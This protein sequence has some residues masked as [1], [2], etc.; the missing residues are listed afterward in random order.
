MT[1]VSII[2]PSWNRAEIILRAVDSALA[3]TLADVEVIVVDNGSTDDTLD[4]LKRCDDPRLSVVVHETNLGASGGR[5]AGLLAAT[6]EFVG[7]LDS[8]DELAPTW[9][10]YL[11]AAAGT[12]TWVATC[13]FA[14]VGPDGA[15]RY[16]HPAKSLGPAFSGLVGPF[17]AGT[18]IVNRHVLT[19]LGGYAEGLAYSENTELALRLGVHCSV[20]HNHSVSVD[21]PLLRWHHDESHAYATPNRRAG[22]AYLLQHHEALLARDPEMLK[23]YRSQLAVWD[24]R[25]GEFKSARQNFAAALRI[26]PF[27]IKSLARLGI[28]C[29]PILARRLWPPLA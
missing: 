9:A 17:Q 28:A 12:A 27:N 14:M 29:C 5:N 21:E 24:A 20:F 1:A 10:Q 19:E 7:F 2:I 6:G 3:Q 15:V 22:C 18:F 4:V 11:T 16:E 25:A 26:Q 8:D 13:G 23:S